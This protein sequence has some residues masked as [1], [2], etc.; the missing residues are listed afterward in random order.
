MTNTS[1]K[2]MCY[3]LPKAA[4][5]AKLSRYAESVNMTRD[6]CIDSL[7]DDWENGIKGLIRSIREGDFENFLDAELEA[8]ANQH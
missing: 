3:L 5:W 6:E 2:V 1:K 8:Y 4:L 7:I